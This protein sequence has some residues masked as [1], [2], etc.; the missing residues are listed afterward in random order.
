M[1]ESPRTIGG[2][3][4]RPGSNTTAR[5]ESLRSTEGAGGGPHNASPVPDGTEY[6][7]GGGAFQTA[8]VYTKATVVRVARATTTTSVHAFPSTI[9]TVPFPSDSLPAAR[10]TPLPFTRN[11]LRLLR[12]TATRSTG[13][14]R[15]PRTGA[16]RTAEAKTWGPRHI[17]HRGR[18]LPTR[19]GHRQVMELASLE[20]CKPPC[21][22]HSASGCFLLL[23]F[24][25]AGWCWWYSPANS[26]RHHEQRS[27]PSPPMSEAADYR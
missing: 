17:P 19:P 24:S 4:S 5:P 25:Q 18:P 11:S 15:A 1:D 8:S 14:M 16:W 13:S 20:F 6:L 26:R 27:P 12:T 7:R 2:G 23:K 3:G 22:W 21:R 10:A 9:M